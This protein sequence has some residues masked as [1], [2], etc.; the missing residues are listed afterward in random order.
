[1]SLR[2]KENTD[3]D[4]RLLNNEMQDKYAEERVQEACNEHVVAHA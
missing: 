4:N 1:M 3:S 2:V